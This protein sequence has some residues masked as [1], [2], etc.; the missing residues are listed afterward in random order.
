[1]GRIFTVQ[2]KNID[3]FRRKKRRKLRKGDVIR[4]ADQLN[5]SVIREQLDLRPKTKDILFTKKYKNKLSSTGT[6]VK[7]VEI[8]NTSGGF[9]FSSTL[10]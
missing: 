5:S 10:S 1:M 2:A 6:T 4:I 9:G 8:G 7:I 3:I